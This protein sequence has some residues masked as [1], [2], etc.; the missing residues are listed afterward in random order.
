MA[1]L[2]LHGT[3]KISLQN[4][5]YLPLTWAAHIIPTHSSLPSPRAV[6]LGSETKKEAVRGFWQPQVESRHNPLLPPLACTVGLDWTENCHIQVEYLLA[7][8]LLQKLF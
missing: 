4:S 6:V 3:E 5:V 1:P 7:K 8:D 2:D